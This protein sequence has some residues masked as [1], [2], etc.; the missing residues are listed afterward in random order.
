VNDYK[1]AKAGF[2]ILSYYVEKDNLSTRIIRG[3]RTSGRLYHNR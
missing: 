3:L 2:N 1:L